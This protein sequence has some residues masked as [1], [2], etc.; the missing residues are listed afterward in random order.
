MNHEKLLDFMSYK[1]FLDQVR[2]EVLVDFERLRMD[3]SNM[4]RGQDP[5]TYLSWSMKSNYFW[6]EGGKK[7]L[8]RQ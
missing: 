7:V 6:V 3:S 4:V 1:F 2:K 5:G 8:G